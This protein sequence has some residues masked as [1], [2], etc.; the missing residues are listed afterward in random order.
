MD[1]K[2]HPT[3][4]KTLGEG[5]RLFITYPGPWIIAVTGLLAWSAKF[6]VGGWSWV[7]LAVG[8]GVLLFWPIQEWLIHVFILHF[9]PITIA[10][11]TLDL[12][13]A[14]KH[15]AHH[16]DPHRM[17][18]TFIPLR[19]LLSTILIALPTLVVLWSL[20]LPLSIGLTA[21]AVFATFGLVYEWVHFLVHTSYK[22]KTRW[23]RALWQHHKWHHFKNE[24]YWF[25]VSRIEG[26][27]LLGTAP[28]PAEVE[29]SGTCK[30]L[31]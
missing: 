14:Q 1:T 17:D 23:Y 31:I 15:R 28:S 21:V 19:T 10:G 25:G 27:T 11:H 2:N 22:A 16:A 18:L 12:H 4:V 6:Y 7:D 8:A 13:V 26:D 20:V 5:L 30:T 29:T 9:K 24:N 3:R